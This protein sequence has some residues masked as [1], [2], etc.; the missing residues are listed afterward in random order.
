MNLGLN[1]DKKIEMQ[2]VEIATLNNRINQLEEEVVSLQADLEAERNK[3]NEAYEQT[4][5][6]MQTLEKTQA[7]YE[8]IIQDLRECQEKYKAQISQVQELKNK[9]SKEFKKVRKENKKFKI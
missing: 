3:P 5:K 1:K 2:Q 6:M 7:E 8:L 9:Y 4:K